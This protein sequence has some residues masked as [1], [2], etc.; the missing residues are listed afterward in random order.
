M[1]IA[2]DKE[3]FTREE[4]RV[5]KIYGEKGAEGAI[6][7]M[8]LEREHPEMPLVSLTMRC[9]LRSHR[10]QAIAP[11]HNRIYKNSEPTR[12]MDPLFNNEAL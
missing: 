9:A 8:D 5:R 1:A 11:Q 2:E 12:V 10:L 7:C 3:N 4:I 6:S